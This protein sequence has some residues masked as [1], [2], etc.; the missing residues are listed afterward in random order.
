MRPYTDHYPWGWGCVCISVRLYFS[1]YLS[2]CLCPKRTKWLGR[3][4]A[5]GQYLPN[6]WVHMIDTVNSS[7]V[8][9]KQSIKFDDEVL[10]SGTPP[11]GHLS[12]KVIL[13]IK[14]SVLSPKSSFCIEINPS[15]KVNS[16]L[17]SLFPSPL[18]DLNLGVP[19]Y[20]QLLAHENNVQA[21]SIF[22]Y[23]C[24]HTV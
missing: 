21:T 3:H 20:M 12:N 10:Y 9:C 11:H 1:T 18:G 15:N 8:K 2:V 7:A 23:H 4:P 6:V 14:V 5:W 24:Q 17:R 22:K 16:Q 13:T 19:L